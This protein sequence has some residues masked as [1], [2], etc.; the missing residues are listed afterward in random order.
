MFTPTRPSIPAPT[1]GPDPLAEL[2]AARAFLMRLVDQPA[3]PGLE[4]FIARAGALAAAEQLCNGDIPEALAAHL[5]R[6][7]VR[8]AAAAAAVDGEAAARC[9]ARL[10][11]PEDEPQWPA[12]AGGAGAVGLW[13]RG[14]AALEILAGPSITLTGSRA[15]TSLGAHVAA[16][17]AGEL[18]AAG[19]TVVTGAGF[20]IDAAAVRGALAAHGTTVAVLGCGID[21]VY[22]AAHDA[23]LARIAET[24]L[25]VSALPPGTTPGR[26]HALARHR[27]LAALGDATVVVEAAARSG[28]LHIAAAAAGLGLPVL[29]VPGATSSACSVGPHRLIRQGA[30]LV[31][32][33]ADV[34]EALEPAAETT[35]IAGA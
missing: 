26:H 18:A 25:L 24:G 12:R 3:A 33:A 35:A 31:T 28:A 5:P 23:L 22:P 6:A 32:R 4:Q 13:V 17:L 14:H 1:S 19:R 29:A 21:R 16:D 10:L 8:A 9:G 11:I 15:A 20:G 27:L 2:R 34:L 7:R 30:T